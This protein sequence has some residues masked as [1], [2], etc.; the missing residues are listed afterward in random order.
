[1]FKFLTAFAK[2]EK[3][4]SE[5]C[6]VCPSVRKEQLGFQWVDFHES[7][8]RTGALHEDLRTFTIKHIAEFLE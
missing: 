6:Y 2:L 7:I 5:L 8:F 3:N 4:I 1:M